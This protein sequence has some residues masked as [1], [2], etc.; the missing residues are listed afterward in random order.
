MCLVR[1]AQVA[2]RA[3][4]P[5]YRAPEVLFKCTNQTPGMSF[6]NNC[7]KII[8]NGNIYIFFHSAID[9]W[10]SGIIMLCIMSATLPFF[11]CPDDCTALAEITT[12]F[13]TIKMTQCARK[14]GTC[15]YFLDFLFLFVIF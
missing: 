9:L 15:F 10:A 1:P 13:G 14:L 7:L 8:F 12:I 5:G 4:T 2:S 11:R 3:G 6:K